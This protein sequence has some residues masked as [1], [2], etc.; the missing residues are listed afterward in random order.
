MFNTFLVEGIPGAGKSTGYYSVLI[1]MLKQNHKEFLNNVW[2]IHT[3]AT[4]AAKFAESIGLDPSK[5]TALDKNSYL[6]K[7]CPEY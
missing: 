3:D 7:I 2:V 4:K 1:D 5:V 6:K